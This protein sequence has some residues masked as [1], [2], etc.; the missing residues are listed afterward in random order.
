MFWRKAVKPETW[1]AIYAAIIGTSA[2]LLNLKDWFDS[3]IISLLATPRAFRDAG[4]AGDAHTAH[5]E[6]AQH[7]F[8]RRD[9]A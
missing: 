3:G 8:M 9:R 5:M 1:V 2:F 4:D 6:L 7:T